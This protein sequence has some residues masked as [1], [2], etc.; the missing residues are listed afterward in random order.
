M[1]R[2]HRRMALFVCWVS[3]KKGHDHPVMIYFFYVISLPRVTN[4]D[5][6]FGP[7]HTKFIAGFDA[8]FSSQTV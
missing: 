4:S 7:R 5:A 3:C 8:F 6:E 2:L 1:D